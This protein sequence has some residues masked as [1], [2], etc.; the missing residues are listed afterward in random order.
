MLSIYQPGSI[1]GGCRLQTINQTPPSVSDFPAG[2]TTGGIRAALNRRKLN[3]HLI[4]TRALEVANFGRALAYMGFICCSGPF[5]RG[6]VLGFEPTYQ[7]HRPMRARLANSNTIAARGLR[8]GAWP[9]AAHRS[10]DAADRERIAEA[11]NR[12]KQGPCRFVIRDK[13][14][15]V[16]VYVDEITGEWRDTTGGARGNGLIEL[17]AMMKSLPYNQA[18]YWLAW[19]CGMDGVPEVVNA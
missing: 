16:V 4:E 12:L 7:R 18:G 10:I 1:L 2:Q 8:S 6:S 5:P 15:K 3:W 14:T 9:D 11:N 19:V 17:A 13:P